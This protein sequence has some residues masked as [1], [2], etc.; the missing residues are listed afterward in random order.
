MRTAF[1]IILLQIMTLGA[2]SQTVRYKFRV[3]YEDYKPLANT[4]FSINGQSLHTDNRGI[5]DLSIPGRLSYAYVESGNNK[6]Y[7]IKYP[8]DGR[9]VL[10]KDSMDFVDIFISRPGSSLAT[11]TDLKEFYASMV[12]TQGT[13]DA[14]LMKKLEE[15]NRR[16]YDSLIVLFKANVLDDARLAN[17]RLEFFPL[18]S[19]TLNHYLNEARDLNDDFAALGRALNN[20]GAYEQLSGSIYNYTSIYEFLNANKSTYEQAIYTYWNSKELSL[21]F[22]SLIDFT[23]DEIHKSY[24]LDINFSFIDRIYAYIDEKDR[25]RKQG[26]KDQ[27]ERDMAERSAV[28]GRRLTILGERISAFITLLNNNNKV[29]D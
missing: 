10:P 23:L 22:S 17:G 3:R 9:A 8:V 14:A 13:A 6:T 27:L 19:Q 11:R 15:Q 28:I 1:I 2:F 29:T 4:A 25:K 26:L 24:I 20:R 5:I 12:K 21:K 16:I 18:I 7:A